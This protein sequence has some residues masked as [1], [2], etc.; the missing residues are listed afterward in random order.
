ML[1]DKAQEA[2][3]KCIEKWVKENVPS[4]TDAEMEEAGKNFSRFLDVA[5]RIQMRIGKS[6]KD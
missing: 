3:A 2:A 6:S 1:P 5:L 4:A